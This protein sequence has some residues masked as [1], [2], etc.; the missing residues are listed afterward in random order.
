MYRESRNAMYTLCTITVVSD[1]PI[2]AKKAIDAAYAE[3]KRLEALLNYYAD[4]SEISAINRYAG[5]SPVKVHRETYELIRK[6]VRL[7]DATDGSFNPAVGPLVKLW[8]AARKT[9]EHPLP[10]EEEISAT[11]RLIDYSKIHINEGKYEIFL[12]EEGMEIDLGGIAK[13]YAADRAINTIKGS[14][15][16]S[17]LVSIAGDI[18]GEGVRNGNKPWIVGIQNPRSTGGESPQADHIIS[19]IALTDAAVSTSGDYERFFFKEGRRYHHIIDPRTGYPTTSRLISV[20]VVG[21][22]GVTADG[23]STGVFV[24]GPERGIALLESLRL[25]GILVDEDKNVYLTESLR[26]VIH[27]LQDEYRIMEHD[28]S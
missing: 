21:S 16:Q 2:K 8:E 15:I 11:L 4:D 18:R 17:A 22:E 5:K 9:P 1:S 13:G 28:P 23:I 25:G 7:A 24:L 26:G 14:G 20:S 6:A 3:I 12:E 10:S 19:T 27:M